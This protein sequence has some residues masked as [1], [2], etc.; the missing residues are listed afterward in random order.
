MSR[1]L[2]FGF[3]QE[4][5]E[6]ILQ[7]LEDEIGQLQRFEVLEQRVFQKI[8]PYLKLSEIRI[9]QS[10]KRLQEGRANTFEKPSQ[11]PF[12]HFRFFQKLAERLQ[13][14]ELFIP[15]EEM[16]L[17][18]ALLM[19]S[20]GVGE[21]SMVQRYLFHLDDPNRSFDTEKFQRVM[22]CS[23]HAE[24]PE[25]EKIFLQNIVSS[26]WLEEYDDYCFSEDSAEL[27]IRLQKS[28]GIGFT[29][30]GL[31]KNFEK[32]YFQKQGS[33]KVINALKITSLSSLA[34]FV[35]TGLLI[36]VMI[37]LKSFEE[38]LYLP[39]AILL[40][41]FYL[42]ASGYLLKR[43]WVRSGFSNKDDFM[44]EMLRSHNLKW[45]RCENLS[46]LQRFRF[47]NEF[48]G[49]KMRERMRGIKENLQYLSLKV[50]K[51]EGLEQWEDILKQAKLAFVLAIHRELVR[52]S[53]LLS[54]Q[55]GQRGDD[56][57]YSRFILEKARLILKKAASLNV[58]TKACSVIPFEADAQLL[59][60]LSDFEQ[61]VRFTLDYL[62][63][64]KEL[65]LQSEE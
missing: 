17:R 39:F 34:F 30:R 64:E 55:A 9:Q 57:Q 33:I 32:E 44:E 19:E 46:E 14:I 63:S 16:V 61:Q 43:I 15:N 36:H 49:E 12:S 31:V 22:T 54:A 27:Q 10:L 3:P 29:G 56:I 47:M 6:I 48:F 26:D 60:N 51:G 62:E 37:F 28:M 65:G 5:S 41:C 2:D 8:R 58:D 50:L 53:E 45:I 35:S 11:S 23:R 40:W 1:V 24:L 7:V 59:K 18:V 52:H 21:A 38:V 42:I 13:K 4:V 25:D 20:Q